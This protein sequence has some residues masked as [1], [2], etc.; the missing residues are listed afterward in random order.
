MKKIVCLGIL[1]LQTALFGQDYLDLLTIGKGITPPT[2]FDT[3]PGTSSISLFEAN[4]LLPIPISDKIALMTG[5]NGYL[6]RLDITPDYKNI[7]LFTAALQIGINRGLDNGWSATHLLFPRISTTLNQNRSS[8]QIG[9]ANI[10]QHKDGNESSWGIGLYF[11]T[12]EQG[13]MIVPLIS[14]FRRSASGIWEVNALLPARADFNYKLEKNTK[15]GLLFEGLG[16]SFAANFAE[17]GPSYI[18]RSS[19]ELS[20]YIQF[21][22]AQNIHFNLRGGY[23]FFR[24]YRIFEAEDTVKLSFINIFPNDPRTALNSSISDGAFLSARM[25]YR[26]YLNNRKVN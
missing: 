22:I 20:T 26:F 7:D 4:V 19:A 1:F 10:L 21:Q 8:F 24:G 18:Q 23:A 15:L 2:R 6:N 13:F 25:I 9:M 16:N 11:N 17:I 12:E 3:G 5:F 14:F